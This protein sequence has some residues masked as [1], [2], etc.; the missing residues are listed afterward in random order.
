MF[1]ND[2]M[3]INGTQPTLVD[4]ILKKKKAEKKRKKER[5][6]HNVRT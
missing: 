2:T 3:L 5:E 1:V 4:T 6:T